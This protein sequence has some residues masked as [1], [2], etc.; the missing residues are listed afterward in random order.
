MSA[1]TAIYST[2]SGAGAVTAI[3][4]T[5]I[6]PDFLAQE[7]VLPAIVT[8]RAETEY[9]NTIHSGAVIAS[10]IVMDAWC[11]AA[12][13]LGAETLADV[14]VIAL[15]LGNQFRIDDRRIEFDAETLTFAT[16]LSAVIWL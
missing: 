10:R 12:T 9:T 16:I 11:L 6:Y 8:Q 3:V 5:R 14:V 2:L 7:I 4:G 1:E 15:P 13:R